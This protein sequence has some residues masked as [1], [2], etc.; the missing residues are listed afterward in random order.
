MDGIPQFLLNGT[1]RLGVCG[2]YRYSPGELPF[3]LKEVHYDHGMEFINE[4]LLSA[5]M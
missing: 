4:S 3:P 5:R 1:N 2:D